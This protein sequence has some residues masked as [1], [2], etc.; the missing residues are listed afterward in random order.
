MTTPI[1]ER[2]SAE[3]ARMRGS[4]EALRD[5]VMK[6]ARGPRSENILD[7]TLTYESI[8]Q[9]SFVFFDSPPVIERGKGSTLIDVDGNEYIDLHAG[10]TV[11]ALGHSNEEVNE[12]IIEQLGRFS[13]SLN[14]RWRV[15]SNLR[16]FYVSGTPVI[17]MPRF[18]GQ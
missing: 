13:H 6:F 9:N 15:G 5:R 4:D 12:A 3:R 14:F 2:I 16:V 7:K 1:E 11:A 10:F 17:L 8:G 18:S